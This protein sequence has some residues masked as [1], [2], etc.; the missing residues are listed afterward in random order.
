MNIVLIGAGTQ[1]S[2]SLDI[3]EK[4]KLH[5]IVGIIDSLKEIGHEIYGYK[6][7]GRQSELSSLIVKHQI[8]GAVI[9]IG[10]NWTRKYIYEEI[11]NSEINLK[12]PNI[13]HPSVIISSRVKIGFGIIAMAGVIINANSFLGNFTNYFTNSNVEHDAYINDYVSIS[14]G[15]VLGGKVNIGMCSAIALNVTI[16]DRV[17]IGKNVVV[18]SASLV[19][20][21]VPDDVLIYGNPAKIIRKRVNGEKFLN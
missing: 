12:W 16:F 7:I 3:I 9:T 14:A 4:Q 1:L 11:L 20:K 19:T 2:Y 21:D 17:K 8:E 5:N 13:I 6:I 10:D 18:G 15:V